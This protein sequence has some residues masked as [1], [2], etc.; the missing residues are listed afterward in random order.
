MLKLGHTHKIY[1]SVS[2]DVLTSG[3]EHAHNKRFCAV[4]TAR[5]GLG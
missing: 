2:N 3:N 5:Q 1:M 4:G